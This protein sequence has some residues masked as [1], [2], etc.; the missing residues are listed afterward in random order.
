[1]LVSDRELEEAGRKLLDPPSSVDEILSLLDKVEHLMST[2]EQSPPCPTMWKLY[3]LIG[4]LVGPKHFQ[5]SDAD[6]KVAVAASISRITFITA[7]D[8]TYDDDQMKEVFQL[9]VS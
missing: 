4:A 3:P 7:P 9:I 2:I 5:H 1:M 8:L 6:V